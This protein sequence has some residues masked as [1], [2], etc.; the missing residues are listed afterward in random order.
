MGNNY[1][2]VPK[3]V[4][5]KCKQEIPYLISMGCGKRFKCPKCDQIVEMH[6]CVVNEP[7]PIGTT[8]ANTGIGT[9]TAVKSTK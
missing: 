7:F 9:I 6:K 4:C 2:Y 5:Y 3:K 8:Y 1:L